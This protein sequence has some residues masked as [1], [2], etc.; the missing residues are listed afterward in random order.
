[1]TNSSHTA[2]PRIVTA[3]AVALL[4]AACG[5]TNNTTATPSVASS[6]S[7]ASPS[8]GPGTNVAV[9]EKEFAIT[10]SQASFTPG[11]YTFNIQNQGSFPHDLIIEGPGVDKKTSPK[12]PGGESGS[13]T[14]NLQKGTYELWC[15][16]DGHKA[17]GMKM[18]IT[19]A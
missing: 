5:G 7:A 15:G 19:V 11:T 8:S 1:M 9:T 6:P 3:V 18:E 16:V 4:L 17:K 12:V 14:V 10:L 13:L 2:G